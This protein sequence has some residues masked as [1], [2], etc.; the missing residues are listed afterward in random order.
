M[1]DLT[2]SMLVKRLSTSF[3]QNDKWGIKTTWESRFINK[4]CLWPNTIGA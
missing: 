2:L 1:R 4:N 3:I